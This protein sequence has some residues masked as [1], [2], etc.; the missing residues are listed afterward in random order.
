MYVPFLSPFAMKTL[1][2]AAD[3][4]P[5]TTAG[6]KQALSASADV[7]VDIHPL[8]D[9]RDRELSPYRFNA[10]VVG[11]FAALTLL[12][13]IVGVYSVMAAIVG[14]RTREYGVRLALGA[15]RARINR[16]V[17]ATAS[18]P[19][20]A[21]IAA[22]MALAVWSSRLIAGLL[23]GVAPL[24]PMSF[25]GAAV[26]LTITAFAAA[27]VPATRASRVD[28]IIALRAE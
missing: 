21:G 24:D 26:I 16:H 8:D 13:A 5:A 19:I 28:P 22:G 27:A 12:L 14:E 6:I 4:T 25:A 20:A 18:V 1:V 3:D 23:Y 9:A 17:L 11:G 10:I 15:T 2:I 7:H